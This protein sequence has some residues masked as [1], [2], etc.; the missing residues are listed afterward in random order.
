MAGGGGEMVF[1][2]INGILPL[3]PVLGPRQAQDV[4][5]VFAAEF[6]R[7]Q[8]GEANSPEE[9]RRGLESDEPEEELEPT[10]VAMERSSIHIVI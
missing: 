6:S 10:P 1:G 5:R 7:R 3:P 8:G 4:T 2:T 9:S